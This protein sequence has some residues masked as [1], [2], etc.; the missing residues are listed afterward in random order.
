MFSVSIS[1]NDANYTMNHLM[2]TKIA[3]KNEHFHVNSCLTSE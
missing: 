2:N 3:K 1:R